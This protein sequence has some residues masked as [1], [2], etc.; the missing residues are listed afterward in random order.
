MIYEEGRYDLKEM[1]S[2]INLKYRLTL[3]KNR[4]F[5]L[6]QTKKIDILSKQ[7]QVID[8]DTGQV[9]VIQYK[10]SLNPKVTKSAQSSDN[11]AFTKYLSYEF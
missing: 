5:Q 6:T 10:E 1:N 11:T 9:E 8:K 7:L 3:E 2:L 4:I